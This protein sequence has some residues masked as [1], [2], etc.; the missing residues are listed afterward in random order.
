M[1]DLAELQRRAYGPDST[2]EQR[3]AAETELAALRA[4]ATEPAAD[5]AAPP[6]PRRT[7]LPWTLIALTLLAAIAI[8]VVA[9]SLPRSSLEVFERAQTDEDLGA[10]GAMFSPFPGLVGTVRP[11][12]GSVRLLGSED[13]WRVYAY[14]TYEGLV[15]TWSAL[16]EGGSAGCANPEDFAVRGVSGTTTIGPDTLTVFW[17]PTGDARL[18]ALTLEEVYRQGLE[19]RP[20]APEPPPAG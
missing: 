14:L 19:P 13:E 10:P 4:P 20:A 7:L 12:P 1:S 9:L 16:G 5:V 18:Y 8:G 3:A 6:A 2:P 15:C 17:G 11:E